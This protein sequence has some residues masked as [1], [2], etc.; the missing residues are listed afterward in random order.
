MFDY[1]KS[2]FINYLWLG[3][4]L[5]LISALLDK[6]FNPE[7]VLFSSFI[8]LI[9]TVGISIVVASV[10]TYASGTSRF[11]EKIR[12]LLEE[13]IVKR[14]FL[15]NI[16]SDSKKEALKYILSPS[17]KEIKN[18]P[19]INDYY[20]FYIKQALN[21]KEK[22]VRSNY[23]SVCRAYFDKNKN[24]VAVDLEISYRL[25]PSS[26]GFQDIQLGFEDDSDSIVRGLIINYPDGERTPI[27]VK[28]EPVDVGG[29]P[30]RL[31]K[32]PPKDSDENGKRYKHID[33]ELRMT[34]FG[35]DHWWMLNFKA[36]QPT[37]GFSFSLTC[38]DDIKI[39][40]YAVFVVG[41]TY[42][43]HKENDYFI[44]LTCHQ[45]INE[46]SGLSLLIAAPHDYIDCSEEDKSS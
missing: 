2:F 8:A 16:D 20:D 33:V 6:Y 37:D 28:L 31:F 15:S 35:F 43:I 32:Y 10:F 9:S 14:Q 45:W 18:I 1:L 7:D 27:D 30:H 23:N 24:K 46:G 42:N 36:M 26:N 22:C 12:G 11:M 5:V 21:V 19:N 34:G 4:V 44:K 38:D 29:Q 25:Y 3:I 41:A 17:E 39:K 13:I 40:K